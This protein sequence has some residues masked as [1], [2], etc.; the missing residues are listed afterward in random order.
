[1][2]SDLNRPANERF[3]YKHA[4]NGV[5]RMGREEGLT[6]FFRGVVPNVTRAVLMNASQLATWVRID[7]ETKEWTGI[8]DSRF[9]FQLSS[10]GISSSHSVFI[11][12][13][14]RYDFFKDGLLSSGYFHE[15]TPLHVA[16]SALAGTVATTVCSP[17][18]VIK[19]R[20]MNANGTQGNLIAKLTKTLKTEGVGFLFRGWTPAW[21]RLSPNVSVWKDEKWWFRRRQEVFGIELEGI[22]REILLLSS[23]WLLLSLSLM[24]SICF[25]SIFL[26]CSYR[27]SSPSSHWR[28]WGYWWIGVGKRKDKSWTLNPRRD[29]SHSNDLLSSFISIPTYFSNWDLRARLSW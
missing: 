5:I 20:V 3:G 13:F 12:P 17:A 16:A 6:S 24:I 8:W 1:M 15:G 22:S 14:S 29:A 23:C 2:T 25:C 4:L 21:I 26:Q 28:N 19:A 11:L 7:R 27:P 18:D 10:H 9:I